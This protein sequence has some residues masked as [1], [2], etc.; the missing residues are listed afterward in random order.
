MTTKHTSLAAGAAGF[1]LLLAA[2]PAT[3]AEPQQRPERSLG[4]AVISSPDPYAG[5]DRDLLV[6]PTL[7]L[8]AGRLRV[9][10]VRVMVSAVDAPAFSLEAG[11]MP[12]FL[13][14][15][16]SDSPAL[17]GMATRHRS[18]DAVVEARWRR[19][20]LITTASL[21]HDIL[22]R[23]H[24]VEADLSVGYRLT[25]AAN[26]LFVTP[27][28]GLAWQSA[29]LTDYYFGVRP[30]EAEPGRPAY[31]AGANRGLTVGVTGV[32]RLG[33]RWALTVLAQRTELGDE[34]TAS[35]IVDRSFATFA[36][37]GLSRSF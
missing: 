18:A 24:G 35:P 30:D 8:K 19:D 16:A 28:L 2:L 31:R 4:L 10:G 11:V 14:Y 34:V 29:D 26:R 9:E 32:Y 36:L 27:R 17:A 33:R 25:L 3:A 20:R 1:L 6:V 22:G 13:G 37:V 5:T 15:E 7:I 21:R 23:S 12:R